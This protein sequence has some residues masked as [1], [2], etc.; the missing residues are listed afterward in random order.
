MPSRCRTST[1]W[2]ATP[3]RARAPTW[4][5]CLEQGRR[6][7]EMSGWSPDER[8]RRTWREVALA[9]RAAA[10]SA[11]AA[12]AGDAAATDE[13]DRG[14][15]SRRGSRSLLRCRHAHAARLIRRRCYAQHRPRGALPARGA[16]R[17]RRTVRPALRGISGA[18]AAAHL[19]RRDHHRHPVRAHADAQ[20]RVRG[21]DRD[22]VVARSPRSPPPSSSAS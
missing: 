19:R 18:R 10:A 17:G 16:C 9:K 12:S 13:P 15:G 21:R 5:C 2:R 1:S 8:L 11:R 3:A 6:Y 20:R 14:W 7:M 4:R 22:E